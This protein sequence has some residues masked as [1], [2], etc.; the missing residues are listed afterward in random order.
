MISSQNI[1]ALSQNLIIINEN[2]NSVDGQGDQ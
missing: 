2:Y 1:L